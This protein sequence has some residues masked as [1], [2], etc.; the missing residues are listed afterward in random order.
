MSAIAILIAVVIAFLATL[1]HAAVSGA[2]TAR[3]FA[4]LF[5]F[6]LALL[7]LPGFIH[8]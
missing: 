6:A 4:A 1:I 5:L 2:W 3:G 7:L 8:A